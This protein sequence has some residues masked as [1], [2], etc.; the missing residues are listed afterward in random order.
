MNQFTSGRCVSRVGFWCCLL[1]AGV[2]AQPGSLRGADAP[3]T[4]KAREGPPR[5]LVIGDEISSSSSGY[6]SPLST[7][8]SGQALV[9][10][11]P[12]LAGSS[13]DA[14]G[15]V[16]D[17]LG[18]DTWDLVLFNFGLRDFKDL[19]GKELTAQDLADYQA[20][21]K[22]IVRQLKRSGAKLVWA[23]TTPVPAKNRYKCKPEDVKRY[24]EAAFLVMESAKVPIADLNGAIQG[25]LAQCQTGDVL[26]KAEG[27]KVLAAAAASAIRKALGLPEPPAEAHKGK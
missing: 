9:Q 4:Q 27:N 12:G 25:R 15:Q 8:L 20:N 23:N 22:R 7:A 16:R 3:A 1:A 2:L 13:K 17:W 6:L 14:P 21:L 10:H 11:M 5:V 26:F 24:N 19:D 18:S